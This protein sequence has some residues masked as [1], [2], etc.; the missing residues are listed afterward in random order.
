[1]K[2]LVRA[3]A[4]VQI[5]SGHIMRC[6]TL[7]NCLREQGHTVQFLTRA[8][9]GHLHDVILAQGF[10]CVLLPKHDSP[11]PFDNLAHST[12]LGTTQ[13]QDFTDCAPHIA[14]FA[15]DW[16]IC[17]HYALSA[18]WEYQA[19]IITG[20]HILA[21]DDL[22][23]R[24]HFADIVLDQ[25]LAHSIKQYQ[26]LIPKKCRVLAGTRYAL[27]RP[28][29]TQWRS[30]S[31]IQ[32]HAR[33]TNSHVFINLGGV[34][35]DNIT[36]KVLEKLKKCNITDINVSVIMGATAP[37]IGSIKAFAQNAP[38]ECKILL[39]INNIAEIMA[40]SDWAIGAAGSTSWERCCMGL[41][42]II[43]VLAENQRSIAQ[44][45]YQSDAAIVLDIADLNTPKLA[46]SIIQLRHQLKT[47][48]QHAQTICDGLGTMRVVQ[49]IED[50]S[51]FSGSLNIRPAHTQDMH[52]IFKWRNH[53]TIRKF[54]L[55]NN[56]LVWEKHTDWFTKQ[57]NNPKFIMFIY[58]VN[59][60]PSGY[61]SFKKLD[62]QIWEWGFYTAPDCPHGHGTR[63]GRLAL[64]CVF[65]EHGA[66][67]IRGVV[68][69]HNAASLRM[70]EKLGFMRLQPH[71]QTLYDNPHGVIEFELLANNFLF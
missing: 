47:I 60:I 26:K 44:Q 11:Q 41:P 28:E 8:H 17:D 3:D 22:H 39:N 35:K 56:E 24:S 2:F 19:N 64:A 15:P 42:S 40:Q 13:I 14:Q 69:A 48:S 52:L 1:M 21:I 34:D 7:A 58:E 55:Q 53:P 49:H 43:L 5:G 66:Q 45:L 9:T 54:M 20:A 57:L 18:D 51:Q 71:Q 36:L 70:H 46:Q 27:L 4:S 30:K 61:V 63:M 6:L 29:F 68:L 67:A 62:D 31:L 59:Q 23:D 25:N 37:H 16:I 33:Q 10:K 65:A 32:R 12:W 50:I 38:F